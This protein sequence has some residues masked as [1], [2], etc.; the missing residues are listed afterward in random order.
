MRNSFIILYSLILITG[1][2]CGGGGGSSTPAAGNTP[3]P[4]PPPSNKAPTITSA[5]NFDIDENS[6]IQI[7]ILATDPENS[8]LSYSIIGGLDSEKFVIDEQSGVL[9]TKDDSSFNFESP[10]DS[11][12][13]NVFS[14]DLSVSD[15]DLSAT[16]SLS[17]NVVNVVE[18]AQCSNGD[19]ITVKENVKGHFYTFKAT[20]PEESRL[21]LFDPINVLRK[22]T[23]SVS[24]DF[25]NSLSL[26]GAD[27]GSFGF[28]DFLNAEIEGNLDDDYVVKPVANFAD[29]STLECSLNLRIQDVVDEV[30]SGIKFA[31]QYPSATQ[32]NTQDVGD[33]DGDGLTDVWISS[34]ISSADN[35]EDPWDHQGHLLFGKTLANIISNQQG[36]EIVLDDFTSGQGVRVFGKTLPYSSSVHVGNSISASSVS[37]IDGDGI[38]EILVSLFVKGSGYG[39]EFTTRPQAYLLWGNALLNSSNSEIDLDNLLPEEGMRFGGL[40]GIDR[41]HIDAISSDFDGDGIPD[42]AIGIPRGEIRATEN[43][44]YRGQL[45]IVFGKFVKER[46]SIGSIDLLDDVNEIDPNQVLIITSEDEDDVIDQPPSAAVMQGSGEQINTISD[47]D[48]DGLREII[49]TGGIGLGIVNTTAIAESIKTGKGLLDYKDIAPENLKQITFDGRFPKLKSRGDY[50]GDGIDDL[51]FGYRNHSEVVP[52]GVLIPGANIAAF[53][54]QVFDVE[55]T[56]NRNEVILFESE[57]SNGTGEIS[58]MP[59]IDGDSRDEIVVSEFSRIAI[60]L[61]KSLDDLPADRIFNIDD[62]QPGQGVFIKKG[63][64]DGEPASVS[65]LADVDG[66]SLPDLSIFESDIYG[67]GA[68][69]SY[70]LLGADIIETINSSSL[71]IDLN[72]YF[73]GVRE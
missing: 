33:I 67:G 17:L 51:V 58:F 63:I 61:A 16:Q 37:D 57:S 66:D 13:D 71:E 73:R 3:P 22:G 23:S 55:K 62:I 42:I 20:G 29:G 26:G 34:T 7:Q 14:I 32:L 39:G 24:G 2:G 60:I 46:K 21:Q 40:G 6:D 68:K 53:S 19:R 8:A 64:I 9:T 50:D 28:F 69:E 15:G 65:I 10:N 44:V 72:V 18:P 5:D 12:T 35:Y 70:L 38:P 43:S 45:F 47:L 36:E 1:T 27:S 30:K 49:L 25:R 11:N 4:P 48:G 41:T 52:N 54:D 59:D 56:E 31:G